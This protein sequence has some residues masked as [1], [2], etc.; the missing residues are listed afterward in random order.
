VTSIETAPRC[1]NHPGVETFISCSS[2]G[3]PICV[4]CAV[5]APVGIKCK[6][7]ARLPRSA[8]VR[9]K[10]GQAARAVAAALAVAVAGGLVLSLVSYASVGF[11][12]FLLAYGM[13]MLSAEAVKRAGGYYRGQASALIAAG[14]AML[15]YLLPLVLV[16]LLF[17]SVHV[18]DRFRAF[19]VVFGVL[20][21]V[22]AYRQ[23]S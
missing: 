8:R 18:S 17:S 7:C 9:L 22:V 13:G 5:H 4:D 21:A 10:P 11:V 3:D 6:S 23:R 1:V 20:A 16:P 19:Q 15:A 2:C 14:G 12:G